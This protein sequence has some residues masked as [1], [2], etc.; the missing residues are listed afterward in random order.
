MK[1]HNPLFTKTGGERHQDQPVH[2]LYLPKH[3][4]RPGEPTI[5]IAGPN[6]TASCSNL[7]NNSAQYL[8]LDVYMHTQPQHWTEVRTPGPGYI[9]ILNLNTGLK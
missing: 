8:D 9:Y 6:S 3:K 7:E 4:R 2:Q 1:P 5:T